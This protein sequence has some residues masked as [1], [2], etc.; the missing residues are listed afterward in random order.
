MLNIRKKV[1]SSCGSVPFV[2]FLFLDRSAVSSRM[3][4]ADQ[5]LTSGFKL[6]SGLL[7]TLIDQ[8]SHYIKKEYM[9][10][11]ATPN[12]WRKNNGLHHFSWYPSG[13][14][15]L[16]PCEVW[17]WHLEGRA[18]KG[19]K[20]KT[21]V[22]VSMACWIAVSWWWTLREKVDLLLFQNIKMASVSNAP[23][24]HNP[25]DHTSWFCP[26]PTSF[27]P[28]S[29]KITHSLEQ[30][31]VRA[32]LLSTIQY[33]NRA[34][35]RRIAGGPSAIIKKGLVTRVGVVS[36]EDPPLVVSISIMVDDS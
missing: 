36:R 33:W 22:G 35:D 27:C 2:C 7:N 26:R 12:Q 11:V 15:L 1:R 31:D 18:V 13:L 28:T 14:L 9:S 23:L 32:P 10:W 8:N 30:K 6:G 17:F 21:K 3:R 4:S 20:S 29:K 24:P 34:L 5:K 19:I 16:L 25:G